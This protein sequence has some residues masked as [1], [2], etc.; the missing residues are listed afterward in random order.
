MAVGNCD[1]IGSLDV[2]QVVFSQLHNALFHFIMIFFISIT[3]I[4]R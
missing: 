1:R 3:T 4:R 2:A